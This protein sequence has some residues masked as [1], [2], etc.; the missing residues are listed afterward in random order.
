[1]KRHTAYLLVASVIFGIFAG[2]LLSRGGKATEAQP[3][4]VARL[5]LPATGRWVAG[6]GIVEPVSESI[7]VG[8]EIT[9]KL[10]SVLVDEGDTVK[11]GQVLAVL[12]ND[13]YH[14]AVLSAQA[15][16]ADRKANLDK[17]INGA[18]RQERDEAQA[19]VRETETNANNAAAEMARRQHLYEKGVVSREETENFENQYKMAKARYEESLQHFKLIDAEAR[20][21][22]VEMARA[23]VQLA[24]AD[25]EQSQAKYQKT[26]IRSPLDGVILRRH[27]RG[28]EIVVSSANNPDPVFTLGDCHVLRVRVDVDES[29][30]A[31]LRVGERAYVT[32]RTFG[33]RKFWGQVVQVGEQLGKKNVETDEPTE[34]VDKKILET[35]VQLDEGH[36]F[37]VGL[38]V[39]GYIETPQ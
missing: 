28:G 38:R 32:A 11:K 4:R 39:D 29:D 18:R 15:T 20:H 26:F 37:P 23:A 27:H 33:D 35:L 31:Q 5:A 17:I 6:P 1:M 25:L 21:E 10:Q 7:K 12:V 24:Q 13:D 22:D 36:E 34:H 14:A 2:V 3:A 9:G 19:A 16:L 30:V 8:S